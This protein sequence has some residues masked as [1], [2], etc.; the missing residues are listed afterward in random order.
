MIPD[1]IDYDELKKRGFLR[2]RQEG[3]FVLRTRMTSGVYTK[4]QLDLLSAIS[5]K[6]GRGITHATTRQGLEVPFIKYKDIENVEKELQAAGVEIGASGPRLRTI[7]ACPG[8]NWCKSG[9][10]DTFSLAERIEK[11]LGIK[12]G[13]DLPHKFKISISG[14]VNACTRPQASEIGIHGIVDASHA[15]KRIGYAVYLGGCGGRAPRPGFRLDKIFTEDEVLGIV[16]RVVKFFQARARSKQRLA[17]LIEEIGR[18]N[19]LK[20]VVLRNG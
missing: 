13:L 3:F 11:G 7:T 12:C 2:Q 17:L 19:F 9:L 15:E 14:C 10:I 4:R 1:N 18:E 20:E 16:E 6:Y 8:T 5:D